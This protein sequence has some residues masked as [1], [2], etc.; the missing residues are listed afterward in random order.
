MTLPNSGSQTNQENGT[1]WECAI[2]LK[3]GRIWTNWFKRQELKLNKT[4]EFIKIQE[5]QKHSI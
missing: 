3:M 2:I 1:I 5:T 4:T